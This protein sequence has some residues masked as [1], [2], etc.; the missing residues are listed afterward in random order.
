M[1][2]AKAAAGSFHLVNSGF[3]PDGRIIG[4]SLDDIDSDAFRT[5]AKQSMVD[6]RIAAPATATGQLSL[7]SW[8]M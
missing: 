6:R 8:T 1:G 3:I 5:L 4:V 7:P 2:A